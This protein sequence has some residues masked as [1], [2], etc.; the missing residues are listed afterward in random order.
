MAAWVTAGKM[1]QGRFQWVMV[2]AGH[3]QQIALTPPRL[4]L[5]HA[6]AA[7]EAGAQMVQGFPSACR[8]MVVGLLGGSFDPAHQ[9]H[10]HLTH[11]ALRRW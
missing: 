3:S 8:G 4:A 6:A 11:E 1:A 5:K 10:V 7:T 9:G 2:A